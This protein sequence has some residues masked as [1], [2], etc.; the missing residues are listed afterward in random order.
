MAIEAQA[1]AQ[2]EKTHNVDGTLKT[3]EQI[4]EE[5]GAAEGDVATDENGNPIVDQDGDGKP[6]TTATGA[7][8]KP[9]E[10]VGGA[11]EEGS[12]PGGGGEDKSKYGGLTKE[13]YNIVMDSN[14]VKYENG[15]FVMVNAIN[16][17]TD[18]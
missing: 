12:S 15:K 5:G 7:D 10:A 18:P 9:Q 14:Q 17:A 16:P 13:Q 6:D 11:P 1:K 2:Y 3:P 4:A 8:V